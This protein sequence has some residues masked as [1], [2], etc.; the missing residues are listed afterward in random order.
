MSSLVDIEDMCNDDGSEGEER[1]RELQTIK[2]NFK[3]KEKQNK[4]FDPNQGNGALTIS[5]RQ[6]HSR[7]SKGVREDVRMQPQRERFGVHDGSAGE[8]R[9]PAC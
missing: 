4:P 9:L 8:L 3:R 5:D 2:K 7:K 1:N 6:R